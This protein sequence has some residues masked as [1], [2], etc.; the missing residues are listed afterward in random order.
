[1]KIAY[2]SSEVAPFAK[3]GGLADVGG[4]LTKALAEDGHEVAIFMPLYACVRRGGFDIERTGIQV[5]VPIREDRPKGD[6]YRG[7]L[8]GT[9]VPVYFIRNDLYFDRDGLYGSSRGDYLDNAERFIFF[10]RAVLEA[11]EPLDFAP[12]ILHTHDWQAALANVYA[13]TLYEDAPA[14]EKAAVL[15]TIHNLA[16]QGLFWHWD[17]PLTGLPWEMFHYS[18]L[19]FYGKINFLKGGIV[20]ADAINTVSKQYAREI[21]QPD[22]GCGLDEMLSERSDRLY[23]IVNGVDYDVWN[24]AVDEHLAAHYTPDDLSGKA[25]CKKDLQQRLKLKVDP[26]ATVVAM[27]SRLNGQKGLDL[28]AQI[29]EDYVDRNVQWVVL[30]V[31]HPRYESILREHAERCP[32]TMSVTLEFDEA[33][34]HR[35]QGGADMILMPSRYEP[36]GLNQLYGMKYGTVPI[37][38]AT[39]GLI[40]TVHDAGA[41]P[42]NA[43]GF[44]FRD[45]TAD[46]LRDALDRALAAFEDK[47]RWQTIVRNGFRQDWS[48]QRIAADYETLYKETLA[49]RE[50]DK[51]KAEAG[52]RAAES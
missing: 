51:A 9:D 3:T 31:G 36:C 24:P 42:K 18:K 29:M 41:D 30:G 48:W 23:G 13:R 16:Y 35:I 5:T 8:P 34:A 49:L 43:T 38:R 37:V 45:F 14:L 6:I 19:E 25:L 52:P 27:I 47:D 7:T 11:L 22:L 2:I 12:D 15:F 50:R 4:S 28:A 39:G 44:V 33:L 10:C 21:Q 1:M 26:D 32:E 40:D 46:A 20:Y 17:M